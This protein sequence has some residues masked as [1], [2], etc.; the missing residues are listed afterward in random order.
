MICRLL[1]AKESM[2]KAMQ[3]GP[4]ATRPIYERLRQMQVGEEF[5]LQ[6]KEWPVA[7]S[8]KDSIGR[9]A[10]YRDDY[11]VRELGSGEGWVISRVK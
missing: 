7:T 8:P 5:R 11:N 10:R 3:Y 9:S 1:E 2:P 6:P 4:V